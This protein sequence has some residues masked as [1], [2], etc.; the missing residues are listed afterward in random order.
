MEMTAQLIA[1]N[2]Q[3]TVY[4]LPGQPFR[5]EACMARSGEGEVWRTQSPHHLAKLYRQPTS[6]RIRKLQVMVAHPPK[7]PNQAM[8]HT[9]FAWPLALLHNGQGEVLG[10]LM[11]AIAHS[12]DLLD[13][14]HPL[15]RQRTFARFDWR[16]LHVTGL[17]IVS[18]V[19][20]IHQAGY[21]LGDMKP[22]NIL[23]ND[24]AMPAFIDTDSFQVRDPETQELFPC[25]VGSEG[26]TPP[27]LLSADLAQTP[28]NM[29][30]DYF[31]L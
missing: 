30:H 18:M 14:Y 2:T 5:L 20:A 31:R 7:D 27:E 11:Q 4:T 1:P 13:V 15:R 19:W 12:V 21:I 23:V 8:G 17:N 24:H 29:A 6:S 10:F 3:Q 28:Q 22:Q 16:Y 26:F 25:L 9:S